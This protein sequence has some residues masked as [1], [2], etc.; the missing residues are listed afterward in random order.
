MKTDDLWLVFPKEIIPQTAGNHWSILSYNSQRLIR[1]KYFREALTLTQ[2][3]S[4]RCM[5][6][7]AVDRAEVLKS[8]AI[9][10]KIW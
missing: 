4:G 2:A 9:E 6:V 3:E 1:H 8:H 10:F 7:P 5:R